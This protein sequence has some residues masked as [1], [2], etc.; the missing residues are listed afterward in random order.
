MYLFV[1]FVCLFVCLFRWI[2]CCLWMVWSHQHRW[3][4]VPVDLCSLHP[5]WADPFPDT[6]PVLARESGPHPQ[7]SD[8][9]V[10]CIVLEASIEMINDSRQF[11]NWNDKATPP[12]ICLNIGMQK[13]V[14]AYSVHTIPYLQCRHI[15]CSAQ[16][17][18]K[19]AHCIK[20]QCVYLH[21]F[22]F[23]WL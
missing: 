22:V 11:R 2:L 16:L 9:N 1:S 3:Q 18:C 8:L 12:T 7:N 15:H 10:S 17:S 23:H 13:F 6:A 19:Y 4:P 5:S 14:N 21:G 20:I